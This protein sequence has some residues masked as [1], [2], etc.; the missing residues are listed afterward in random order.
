MNRR[1]IAVLAAPAL[2]LVTMGATVFDCS[3]VTVQLVVDTPGYVEPFTPGSGAPEEIPQSAAL[4]ALLG[5][6]A[7][8]N[9]VT[10]VRTRKMKPGGPPRAILILIPGFLGGATTFDPLARD[11]VDAMGGTLEVW[12][13]DRRPNQLED[14]VGSIHATDGAI[15]GSCGQPA[16][17]C[18]AIFQ[19]AQFY[20]PD[21]DADPVGDFPGP[22]DL[23]INLN[24]AFDPQTPL[25]D[26]LGAT[27]VAIRLAQDDVRFLAHWG[28]DTYMRDWATLVAEARAIVGDGGLVLMG[29]HSQGTGWS[30]I[31]A[32]YDL[33]PDPA[34]VVAGHSLIDGL[35][36]L[37]GGG[38]GPGSATKPTLAEYEA[39]VAALEQPG[40]PD[41]YL[42][43]FSFIPLTDLALS[44]EVA[45]VA[46]FFQ[47]DEAS[48]IQ[49]TPTFGSGLV[50][51]LLGAPATNEAVVG[52]FLDDDFSPISAFS[53][54][55]GFSVNGPNTLSTL[56]GFA[57]FY[58]AGNGDGGDLRRWLAF[59]DPTLPVCGPGDNPAVGPGGRGCAIV[60]NGPPS[61]PG[62]SPRM[63]GVEREVTSI[64]DFLKTQFG[65]ANGFEWYFVDGRVSQ[66]FAYGNDSTALV[67][68]ALAADPTHEGP[69]R[70]TQNAFVDVPVLGIGGSNGLT[71]EGKSFDRY[72]DSIATPEADKEVVIIE[73]YAHLDVINARDNDAVAP[74]VDLV[75]RLIQRKLLES[76]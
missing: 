29:G 21:L 7:D 68:E 70:I 52:F 74:I 57:P 75:S 6:G 2:M 71:P 13:V 38:V 32:A 44:S 48:L 31:F 3:N 67:A 19:G 26:D 23:D 53:A 25:V 42:S 66:D 4:T 72:L 22:G 8:L 34:N 51:V 28:I 58:L 30:T 17:D 63:N 73:G 60:D 20:F 46:G 1:R 55:L 18:S 12:S 56:P 15:A 27:R 65:K 14:R 10:T 41:V 45:A 59:D 5:P 62:E 9:R 40:G 47:P 16:G 69:L 11:L 33:D 24:G 36:L 50:S 35:V 49:R 64:A 43:T 61:G 54:S 37:E 39:T 76:F